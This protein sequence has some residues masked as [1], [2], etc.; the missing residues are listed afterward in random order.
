GTGRLAISIVV[1]TALVLVMIGGF[2]AGL[3]PLLGLDLVGGVEVVLSGPAGTPKDVMQLALDR[4]RNRVDSLG[5]AEPDI[6]LLGN[7]FIQVQLP[8]L[9]GQGTVQKKGREYCAISST[10]KSLGCFSTLA[11]AQA[12]AKAQ[13]VQRVLQI[14]GTTARLEERPVLQVISPSDPTYRSLALTPRDPNTGQFLAKG[15]V[16]SYQDTNG[17]NRFTSG[18]DPKYKLGPLVI[19]GANLTKAVAQYVSPATQGS[20]S[21]QQPGWRVVFNLD[22]A[23]SRAF[24]DTTTRLVNLPAP[25]NQLAIVLDGAV[26]SAPTVQGAITGGQGEITLGNTASSQ[27]AK[28]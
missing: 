9:G 15:D 23:G 2:F 4:I 8:G 21:V 12:R 10:K 17:D 1:V 16:I 5:V 27:A 24:A 14:I 11:A 28:N 22:S 25:T 13:S 7:N 18:A 19:T 26:E 20:T 3:R 6:S